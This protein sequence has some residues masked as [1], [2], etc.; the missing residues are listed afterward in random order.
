MLNTLI[1]ITVFKQNL[2]R[3]YCI[4]YYILSVIDFAI[5]FQMFSNKS[6]DKEIFKLDF[7]NTKTPS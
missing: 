3:N 5:K 1:K 2:N 6:R 7:T 4:Q